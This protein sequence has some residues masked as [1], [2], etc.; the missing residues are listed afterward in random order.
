MRNGTRLAAID[1]GSNSFRLE[2]GKYESGQ[3]ERVEYLKETVR[4]G[5]GLN[6]DNVLSL[7]AMQRGWAC[8]ERFKERLAGFRKEQIRAVG[9]QTL[10]QAVNR[11]VFVDKASQILGVP[12][13]V[14]SGLRRPA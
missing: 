13:D 8:L 2:I 12:I 11:Q 10:R 14:V 6:E 3:I 5:A 7:E 1:L 9:T 4:Q